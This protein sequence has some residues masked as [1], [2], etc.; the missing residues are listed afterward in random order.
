LNLLGG[1]EK[2]HGNLNS[3]ICDRSKFKTNIFRITTRSLA[4]V[5][6]IQIRQGKY[7][8]KG[9]GRKVE[10]E[11]GI[12]LYSLALFQEDVWIKTINNS[13]LY[14]SHA[15]FATRLFCFEI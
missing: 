3:V 14:A 11:N 12:Q 15:M 2:N 5:T 7:E 13:L 6:P 8:A 1:A 4:L 9:S 10:K